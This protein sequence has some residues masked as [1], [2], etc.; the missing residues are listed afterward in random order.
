MW[1]YDGVGRPG[2]YNENRTAGLGTFAL[3]KQNPQRCLLLFSRLNLTHGRSFPFRLCKPVLQVMLFIVLHIH[4]WDKERCV[5]EKIV[6]LFKRTLRRFWEERPEEESVGE[7]ENALRANRESIRS[8][9]Q[10][11]GLYEERLTKMI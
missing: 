10:N 2:V 8:T 3:P 4:R 9:I 7:I 11:S 5:C 1:W 6:H